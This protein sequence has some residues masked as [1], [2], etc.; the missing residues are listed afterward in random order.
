VSDDVGRM[1]MCHDLIVKEGQ[2]VVVT[3][4]VIVWRDD[5]R[6]IT[7]KGNDDGG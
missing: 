7:V 6:K 1:R 5:G 3:L 2:L 4:C